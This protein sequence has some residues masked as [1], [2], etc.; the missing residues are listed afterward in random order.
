MLRAL[1][2]VVGRAVLDHDAV[3]HDEHPVAQVAD[4]AE[5]VR[6]EQV[7]DAGRAL[8]VDEQVEDLRLDG[9]VERRDRLVEHDD[10]GARREGARDRDALALP[11]GELQR[12]PAQH[13]VRQADL[14]E[15]LAHALARGP[16]PTAVAGTA[17]SRMRSTFQRG[18]NELSGSW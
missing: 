12:E 8:Q 17:S 4:H 2:D 9:H 3:L 1:E 5:V 11:A 7:A 6:D 13:I 10:G 18:S 15:Q 16:R 14:V